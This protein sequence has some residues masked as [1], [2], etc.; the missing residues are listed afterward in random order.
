VARLDGD[1]AASAARLKAT[2]GAFERGETDILVGTQLI[3]KGFDFAGVSVVGVLNADNLLCRPDFRAEERAF[4]TIVQ[5]TGR[6]GRNDSQGHT[7]IQT[8]QPD[9]HTIIQAA[10]GDYKAMAI[11]Q[12]R[13]REAFGYPPFSRL[14]SITLKHTSAEGVVRGARALSARLKELIGHGVTD[15]HAPA[16]S[17][18]ADTYFMEIMVRI[19]RSEAPSDTKGLIR[20][21]LKEFAHNRL[22]RNISVTVNVDPQG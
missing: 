1:V 15:A 2:I 7:I 14:V 13:D 16:V 10:K 12:L 9:N 6:A 19:G 11:S 22:Y 20:E 21:A 3:T 17:H 4:Q 5:I 8:A 18:I